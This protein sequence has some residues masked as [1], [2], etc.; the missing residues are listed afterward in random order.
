MSDFDLAARALAYAEASINE[1]T[2]WGES[3]CTAWARRWVEQIHGKRMKLP[4]WCSKEQA[5]AYIEKAGSL[6][7][8]WSPAVESYGL[9]VRYG[10]PQAGDV[11]II[12][13]HL[14][15]QVGGIFLAHGLF[16]WRAEPHGARVIRPRPKTIVKVWVCNET[17]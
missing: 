6:E 12:K 7:N 13:T 1:P 9:R 5:L 17:I 2:V 8:L 16:A 3:D 4:K 10:E 15:P 11:G 14:F